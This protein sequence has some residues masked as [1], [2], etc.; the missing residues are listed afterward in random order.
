M[1]CSVS[2]SCS[3]RDKSCADVPL[4]YESVFGLFFSLQTLILWLSKDPGARSGTNNFIEKMVE[5]EGKE[6][7]KKKVGASI[8]QLLMPYDSQ[9]LQHSFPE[10]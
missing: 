2:S 5:N 4:V 10:K 9:A 7:N 8:F 1:Q 3:W 6:Q